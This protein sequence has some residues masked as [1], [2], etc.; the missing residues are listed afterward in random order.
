MEIELYKVK[1]ET[2]EK[3]KEIENKLDKL[4]PFSQE[5]EYER[6]IDKLIEKGEYCECGH[7]Y[8]WHTSRI[9]MFLGGDLSCNCSDF[10]PVPDKLPDGVNWED[11]L[12]FGKFD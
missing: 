3:I 6:Q 4:S 10:T 7:H 2:K 1:E 11:Y 8:M 9:G 5:K 12:N